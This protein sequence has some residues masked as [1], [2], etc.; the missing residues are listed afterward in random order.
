METLKTPF[1]CPNG[2]RIIR[3][4]VE[5]FL[6]WEDITPFTN[7]E[8]EQLDKFKNHIEEEL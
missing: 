2:V 8:F 7:E 4:N 5:T 1:V 6:E 3:I